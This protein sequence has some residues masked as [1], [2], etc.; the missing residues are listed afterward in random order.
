[1][2]EQNATPSVECITFFTD[3]EKKWLES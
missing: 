1:V 2:R 3:L